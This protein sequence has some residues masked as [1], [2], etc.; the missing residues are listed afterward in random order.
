MALRRKVNIKVRQPLSKLVIPVIDKK[1][2]EQLEKVKTLLLGEVN[3]K[4]AEFI[5][6]TAGLITK[7]I[8]P[9]FKTLGKKYG[10]RMKAIA[11]AFATLG[12]EDIAAIE[13]AGMA[14]RDYVLRLADGDV[15]LAKGDYEV[16]S[17]DM[18]GWLVA[19]DG[20]LT[21]ALDIT[22]TDDLRKEG[23]ARELINRIQNLRKESDF[24]VTDK[25]A[26]KIFADGQDFEEIEG[27]LGSFRDYVASQTLATEVTVAPLSGAGNAPEVEW[28]DSAIRIS[29]SRL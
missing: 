21:L 26:V 13:A 5:S 7:K 17:E 18:P 2:E 3:V 10:S 28:N 20:P 12:Q 29:V 27:S 23:T 1:I 8:R 15:A 6:D 4:D 24:D 14:D 22:V 19:T 16:S 25:I 11:A 9:N